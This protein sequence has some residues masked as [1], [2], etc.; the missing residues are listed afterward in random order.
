MFT[1]CK[2]VYLYLVFFLHLPT[3]EML[4]IFLRHSTNVR[5]SVIFSEIVSEIVPVQCEATEMEIRRFSR[6]E[7][8]FSS[9]CMRRKADEMPIILPTTKINQETKIHT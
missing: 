1:I 7:F 8:Y 4:S 3:I 2:L 6:L 5:G 9:Y